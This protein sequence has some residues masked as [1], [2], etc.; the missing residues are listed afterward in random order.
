MKQKKVGHLVTKIFMEN[1]KARNSVLMRIIKKLI[2][3]N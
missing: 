1:F 2:K 3:T